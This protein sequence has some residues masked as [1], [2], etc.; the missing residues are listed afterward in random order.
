MPPNG[1]SFEVQ[2]MHKYRVLDGKVTSSPPETV[3]S[4]GDPHQIDTTGHLVI[5]F[6]Q[7]LFGYDE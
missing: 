2:H 1:R 5:S 3:P 7:G 6:E 4:R